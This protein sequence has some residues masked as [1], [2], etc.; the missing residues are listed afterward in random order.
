MQQ[1]TLLHVV[2]RG[3]AFDV[4]VDLVPDRFD[5]AF[6][7][8]GCLDSPGRCLAFGYERR[9]LL[10]EVGQSRHHRFGCL[11]VQQSEPLGKVRLFGRDTPDALVVA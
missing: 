9:A 5:H 6:C 11:L 3:N 8:F 1:F 10:T 7:L 2:P 4:G